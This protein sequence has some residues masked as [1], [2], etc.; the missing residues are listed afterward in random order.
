MILTENATGQNLHYQWRMESDGNSNNLTNI[1]GATLSNLVQVAAYANGN[2][3]Y[4]EVV[5]TNNNGAATSAAVQL[6][7]NPASAPVLDTYLPTAS[8][9]TYVGGTCP[10]A[11]SSKG[12]CQSATSG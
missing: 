9:T 3:V 7:V 1:P 8:P 12:R 4:Y 5:V 10:L 2:P 6:T 11:R